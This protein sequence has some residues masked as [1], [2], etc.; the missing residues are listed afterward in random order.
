MAEAVVEDPHRFFCHKCS[1]E[2]GSVLP[3]RILLLSLFIHKPLPLYWVMRFI[4]WKKKSTF[5]RKI[6]LSLNDLFLRVNIPLKFAGLKRSFL[7][8]V[9]ATPFVDSS[10]DK[11]FKCQHTFLVVYKICNMC[12]LCSLHIVFCVFFDLF[13]WHSLSWKYQIRG[14]GVSSGH[15]I[16]LSTS[17]LSVTQGTF[18]Q[19]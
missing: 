13:A 10:L 7:N 18:W 16:S 19:F 2:I 9:M 12:N 3:V 4:L 6:I 11:P 14:Y 17:L 8:H 5:T 1:L 15:F